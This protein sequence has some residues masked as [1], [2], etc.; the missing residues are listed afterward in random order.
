MTQYSRH[1]S[2]DERNSL[3][4]Q[5]QL[6]ILWET[7]LDSLYSACLQRR[8]WRG[9]RGIIAARTTSMNDLAVQ[10]TVLQ[11]QY[12]KTTVSLRSNAE[13]ARQCALLCGMLH[14]EQ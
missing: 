8:R 3:R 1:S 7:A 5:K 11:Q 6:R 14:N 4:V 13:L 12:D 2:A 9:G 10:E